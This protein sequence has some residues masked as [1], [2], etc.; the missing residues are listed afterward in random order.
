[1]EPNTLA[2]VDQ[3]VITEGVKFLYAQA[4]ELLRRR[5]DR[6]KKSVAQPGSQS[7]APELASDVF[8]GTGRPSAPNSALADSF[9]DDLSAFRHTLAPYAQGIKDIDPSDQTLLKTVDAMR[10]I[11]EA[12][13][14]ERLTFIGEQRALPGPVIQGRAQID[15]IEGDVAGVRSY[16]IHEGEVSGEVIAKSVETGGT[17]SG[18]DIHGD[19]G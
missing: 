15:K 7:V 12:V 9:L 18:V 6:R 2:T 4:G 13:Y 19:I 8:E 3:A 11:L 1:M 10:K 5:R 14:G 17:A 16:S